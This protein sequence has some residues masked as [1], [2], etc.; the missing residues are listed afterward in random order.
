MKTIVC[1]F[2]HP[3]DEAFGPGGT[4]AK[5]AKKNR[6]Y[7]ICATKG[8]AGKDSRRKKMGVLHDHRASE[9]V[10]SAKILGVKK[11]YFLGFKDGTLSNRKSIS[12]WR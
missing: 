2:A 11:V 8:E 10:A 6:V 7:I 4:I 12:W 3:D 9:L 1:I 5:L